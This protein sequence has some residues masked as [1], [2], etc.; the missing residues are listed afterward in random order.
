MDTSLL[1]YF[2]RERSGAASSLFG[3]ELST[4]FAGLNL[5]LLAWLAYSVHILLGSDLATC[6][7]TKEI[8]KT[9]PP[10]TSVLIRLFPLIK[11]ILSWAIWS[12]G[13]GALQVYFIIY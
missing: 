2:I 1:S 5:Y 12:G 11:S 9:L 6:P 13:P 10:R 4:F 8:L 7:G 3:K